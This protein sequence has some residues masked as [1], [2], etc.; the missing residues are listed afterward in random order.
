MTSPVRIKFGNA[1]S[2][3]AQNWAL[4]RGEVF[5]SPHSLFKINL[6]IFYWSIVD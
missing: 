3:T 6:F 1:H 4:A 2:L 5:N